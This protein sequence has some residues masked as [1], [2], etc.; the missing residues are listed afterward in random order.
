MTDYPLFSD[1]NKD[2]HHLSLVSAVVPFFTEVIK[3]PSVPRFNPLIY[4]CH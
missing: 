4:N 1:I 2:L 3:I